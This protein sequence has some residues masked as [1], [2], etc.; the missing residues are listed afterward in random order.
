MPKKSGSSSGSPRRKSRVSAVEVAEVD[1]ADV[2][3]LP[4]LGPSTDAS[5]DG[6]AVYTE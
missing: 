4:L 2:A 6:V 3:E 5:H 1:V